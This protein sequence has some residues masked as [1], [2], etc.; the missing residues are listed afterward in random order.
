MLSFVGLT[1]FRPGGDEGEALSRSVGTS[2]WGGRRSLPG[3]ASTGIVKGPCAG[4]GVRSSRFLGE[5][6]ASRPDQGARQP[7]KPRSKA[8]ANAISVRVARG[9]GLRFLRSWDSTDTSL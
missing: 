9:A 5:P 6:R 3:A 8:R 2:S 1:V 7:I 4:N